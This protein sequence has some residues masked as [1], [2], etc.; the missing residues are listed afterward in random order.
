ML[1][2]LYFNLIILTMFGEDELFLHLGNL[3]YIAQK[4]TSF[5]CWRK[6]KDVYMHPIF[7]TIMGGE[8]YR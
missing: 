8:Y 1:S 5:I 2:M 3:F 6:L 7:K 4:Q